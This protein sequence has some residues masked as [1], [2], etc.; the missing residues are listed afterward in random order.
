MNTLLLAVCRSCATKLETHAHGATSFALLF[1][2]SLRAQAPFA[3]SVVL[4][5]GNIALFFGP[6]LAALEYPSPESLF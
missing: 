1:E 3:S 6:T 4:C 2:G 5:I